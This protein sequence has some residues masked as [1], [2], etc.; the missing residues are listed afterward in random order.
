[1]KATALI[2]SLLA[3]GSLVAAEVEGN[4]TAVVVQKAP[5]SS[6]NGYQFICVPVDGLDITGAGNA[7]IAL[8]AFLPPASYPE[9]T[10]VFPAD[11]TGAASSTSYQVKTTS[12]GTNYWAL[13]SGTDDIGSSVKFEGGKVLWINVTTSDTTTVFCGEEREIQPLSITRSSAAQMVA[14]SNDSSSSCSINAVLGTTTPVAGDEFYRLQSGSSNYQ[15][16]V[17]TGSAWISDGSTIDATDTTTFPAGEA[18]FYFAM[19]SAN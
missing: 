17:Y 7:T 8:A 6:S 15:H 9:R 2:L 13:S 12:D 19:P 11:S 16:I 4:N 18:F 14:G 3:V 1:M 10:V 5:V